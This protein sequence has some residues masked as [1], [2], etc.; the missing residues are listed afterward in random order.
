MRRAYRDA[1]VGGDSDGREFA[2]AA[3]QSDKLNNATAA[4]RDF[5][6][7]GMLVKRACTAGPGDRGLITANV[8]AQEW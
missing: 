1:H 5:A 4:F 2:V 7:R 3:C 8:D 6:S